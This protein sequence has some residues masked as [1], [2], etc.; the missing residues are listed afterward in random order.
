MTKSNLGQGAFVSSYIHHGLSPRELR[1]ETQSRNLEAGS[2]AE[3]VEDHYLDIN[4]SR[5][6]RA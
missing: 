2:E 5:G 6:T 4:E 3:A 1:E